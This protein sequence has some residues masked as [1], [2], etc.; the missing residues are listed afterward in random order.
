MHRDVREVFDFTAYTSS[1]LFCI[2]RSD[3]CLHWLWYY[4]M[5]TKDMLYEAVW[6]DE[7]RSCPKGCGCATRLMRVVLALSASDLDVQSRGYYFVAKAKGC[8]VK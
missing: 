2:R 4:E 5:T 3:V 7:H 1:R 8:E 6:L